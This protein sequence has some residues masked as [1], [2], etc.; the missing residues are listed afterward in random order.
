MKKNPVLAR[1]HMSIK[2]IIDA[3][4][5]MDTKFATRILPPEGL[6]KA[7]KFEDYVG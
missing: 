6:W 1:G 2:V 5:T 3:T 7:M 4:K